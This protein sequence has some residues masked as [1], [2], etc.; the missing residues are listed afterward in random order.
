MEQIKSE[1]ELQAR[2]E[3]CGACLQ[4][5]FHCEP[6]HKAIVVCGGTGC[7]SADSQVIIDMHQY[8]MQ[9]LLKNII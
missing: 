8:D 2:F 7:L 1:K 3:K 4:K 6:G 5:K 9:N